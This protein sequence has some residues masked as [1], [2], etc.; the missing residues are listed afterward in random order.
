[1]DQQRERD[2]D[3]ERSLPLADLE[4]AWPRNVIAWGY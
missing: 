2:H 4:L 3:L 1:M